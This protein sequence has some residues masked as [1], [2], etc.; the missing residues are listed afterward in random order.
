MLTDNSSKNFCCEETQ[1]G[2]KVL[3]KRYWLGKGLLAPRSNTMNLSRKEKIEC[4]SRE[5]KRM[6]AGESGG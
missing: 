5:E 1:R 6:K 3:G 2:G 4:L